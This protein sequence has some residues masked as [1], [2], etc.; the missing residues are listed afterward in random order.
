[1]VV[2]VVIFIAI[3]AIGIHYT[4]ALYSDYR[5]SPPIALLKTAPLILL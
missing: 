1:M 3:T 2:G 4:G 5:I